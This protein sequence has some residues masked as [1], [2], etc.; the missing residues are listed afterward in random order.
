MNAGL[1]LA[2]ANHKGGVGKTTI[3]HAA[4]AELARRGRRVLM[5]DLDPQAALTA[6]TGIDAAGRSLT[7][8]IGGAMPG[9]LA[10]GDVLREIAPRLDL[11]PADTSLAASELGLVQRLGRERVIARLMVDIGGLYDV[12]ILDCPPSLGL[13]TVAGLVAAHGVLVPTGARA[14]DLRA[15]KVFLESVEAIRADLNP[16]LRVIG[17][18]PTFYD[19][20]R[21]HERQRAAATE[22]AAHDVTHHARDERIAE[23]RLHRAFH[24]GV[25]DI[26]LISST[27]PGASC[28]RHSASNSCCASGA[29][30]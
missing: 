25:G 24:A 23:S 28:R 10:L 29:N 20:R 16:A 1:V 18:V 13:L 17:I 15:V 22:L 4:A 26:S 2:V 9:R 3:A 11:A 30:R 14:S 6:A 8:V 19:A 27:P 12:V 7:E 5:V 21:R